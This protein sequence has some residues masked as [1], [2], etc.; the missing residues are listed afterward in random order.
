MNI[1]EEQFAN[2]KEFI[3]NHQEFLVVG[4]KDP[5]GDCLTSSIGISAVLKKL[6]KQYQL[7]SAGAFKRPEIK[8]LEKYFSN[9]L[10]KYTGSYGPIGVLM[11]DCSE[12]N[13]LG[14]IADLVKDYDTFIIDHHKTAESEIKNSIIVPHAPASAYLVQLIYERFIGK[15][16]KKTA[17]YLFLGMCTDTGFFRFLDESS[18]DFFLAAARLVEAGANPRKISS[19]IANNKPLSTRKLL[20][21]LLNK[22]VPQF[23]GKLIYTYET[24]DDTKK[25]GKKGRDSD[26]LYQLL[27]SVEN[28]KAVVFLRQ[29]TENT[30]TVGFRSHDEIDV[31]AIASVFGG[32]GHKNAAGLSIEGSIN[33]VLPKILKEFSKIF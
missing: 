29:E 3:N 25:Y 19:K 7:L 18:K 32:G 4:H 24:L 1:T 6:K 12:L 33:E 5:D 2:L 13:R 21:I 14:E 20:S 15:L 26:N 17:D 10:N 16:D 23:N 28:V 22:A 11:L 31:S 27:L 9:S 30:C 8:P